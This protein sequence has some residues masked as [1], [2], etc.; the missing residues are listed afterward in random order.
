[1]LNSATSCQ[2]LTFSLNKYSLDHGVDVGELEVKFPDLILVLK[3]SDVGFRI[4]CGN[5]SFELTSY[6]HNMNE[7]WMCWNQEAAAIKLVKFTDKQ[8]PVGAA[9]NSLVSKDKIRSEKL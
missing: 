4:T 8:T 1:M 3:F 6:N 5:N 9:M 7:W 2:R